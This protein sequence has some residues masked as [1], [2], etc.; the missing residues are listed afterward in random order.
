MEH[1][2]KFWE[3]YQKNS[4]DVEGIFSAICGHYKR[5]YGDLLNSD[6][7]H[8]ELY[9]TLQRSSFLQRFNPSRAKLS[10]YFY[11]H[12]RGTAS[13]IVHAMLRDQS[14]MWGAT[15]TT[16]DSGHRK[17]TG[18][19]G[20]LTLNYEGDSDTPSAMDVGVVDEQ[21]FSPIDDVMA[22]ELKSKIK[23]ALPRNCRKIFDRM[24]KGYDA[25]EVADEYGASV[26]TVRSQFR[27]V[28][29]VALSVVHKI[30]ARVSDLPVTSDAR[31]GDGWTAGD[32]QTLKTLY[33]SNTLPQVAKK[34]GRSIG[35]IKSVLF[36]QH[37]TKGELKHA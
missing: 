36:K 13:H 1:A 34:M 5:Q 16:S 20:M 22:L 14:E 7:L 4:R 24:E 10:T 30:I 12:V 9:V 29:D 35:S 23:K 8:Q 26:H 25:I 18:K 32:I 37:I 2:H 31:F 17:I 15:A 3:F 27:T 6:D 28:K 19:M 33:Q 11:N 21:S